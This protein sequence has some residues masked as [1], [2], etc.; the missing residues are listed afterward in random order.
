MQLLKWM[1]VLTQE[2]DWRGNKMA[3]TKVGSRNDPG[4]EALVHIR[5]LSPNTAPPGNWASWDYY[6]MASLPTND[7]PRYS[8]YNTNDDQDILTTRYYR[9]QIG[10]S[11][12]RIQ[13]GIYPAVY[14]TNLR[15][16]VKLPPVVFPEDP[17]SSGYP[18]YRLVS[19]TL[20]SNEFGP[21]Y[22]YEE[23]PVALKDYDPENDYY[24][25]YY[26][27]VIQEEDQVHIKVQDF[28]QYDDLISIKSLDFAA[29]ANFWL[30]N[31]G[32][33]IPHA[34]KMSAVLLNIPYAP[35]MTAQVKLMP[36]GVDND[37][38]EDRHIT[39]YQDFVADTGKVVWDFI[40]Y[41]VYQTG[42]LGGT[43]YINW[44]GVPDI[45]FAFN[46]L[47][48]GQDVDQK[49]FEN[50]LPPMN[51]Y[52]PPLGG[53]EVPSL[54]PQSGVIILSD[55]R[56]KVQRTPYKMVYPHTYKYITFD[57]LVTNEFENSFIQ[58]DDPANMTD[59]PIP[60]HLARKIGNEIHTHV[61]FGS[62]VVQDLNGAKMPFGG[63]WEKRRSVGVQNRGL[64]LHELNSFRDQSIV[65]RLH[66]QG[67]GCKAAH[68]VYRVGTVGK[69]SEENFNPAASF[70]S[71]SNKDE[72]I[73]SNNPAVLLFNNSSSFYSRLP[74][75]WPWSCRRWTVES[76]IK[77][78]KHSDG[79][80]TPYQQTKYYTQ[81]QEG[82][83]QEI[84]YGDIP[85]V[86]IQFN[87]WT[88]DESTE[89]VPILN[90]DPFPV[91]EIP[92][93]KKLSPT[94][95]PTDDKTKFFR[96]HY[97]KKI[98]IS[99]AGRLG[100]PELR[101]FGCDPEKTDKVSLAVEIFPILH[102]AQC[103]LIMKIGY[104]CYPSGCSY[105]DMGVGNK[106][107]IYPF[108]ACK[109][110]ESMRLDLGKVNYKQEIPV[111]IEADSLEFD[112]AEGYIISYLKLDPEPRPA[113]DTKIIY[114]QVDI[115]GSGG[116]VKFSKANDV[117]LSYLITPNKNG[118]G[119][120][121]AYGYQDSITKTLNEDL[122]VQIP[123]GYYMTTVARKECYL[124][125]NKI[126]YQSVY[127][128]FA[129]D[130]N[131]RIIGDIEYSNTF[132]C[133]EDPLYNIKKYDPYEHPDGVTLSLN[134]QKSINLYGFTGYISVVAR[135][136]CFYTS[137]MYIYQRKDNNTFE[138]TS[139]PLN[140]IYECLDKDG[141]TI[142]Y[143]GRVSI[144][145]NGTDFSEAKNKVVTGGDYYLDAK[146]NQ[147]L[148]NPCDQP[149][150]SEFYKTTSIGNAGGFLDWQ[151]NCC[152][153]CPEKTDGALVSPAKGPSYNC[154]ILDIEGTPE[155]MNHYATIGG[156]D[157]QM[158]SK[159]VNTLIKGK[160]KL[161]SK[162]K[163]FGEQ[164]PPPSF[165]DSS[166]Y[167]YAQGV[168]G[169]LG[170]GFLPVSGT[171][172]FNPSVFTYSSV[173]LMNIDANFFEEGT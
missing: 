105:P 47:K 50:E 53:P 160:A 96:G 80:I 35:R 159:C 97:Y 48:A 19:T 51:Y 173:V 85:N 45:S 127:D 150:T 169:I 52:S 141:N 67:V 98:P 162:A 3:Y 78:N 11:D 129:K 103:K 77:Y 6:V 54:S 156:C 92:N 20:D 130:Y 25:Y 139:S 55:K 16:K 38:G 134:E 84:S 30:T 41:R 95:T 163:M 58:K 4:N 153:F 109:F 28:G 83:K 88:G 154:A 40:P 9:Y 90:S 31:D 161:R 71:L 91:L 24:N 8:T 57:S 152:D 115:I 36:T 7:N 81:N 42:E 59:Q 155:S 117:L 89:V 171:A 29:Y 165:L 49:A 167:M 14:D 43:G 146:G 149:R 143:L 148:F 23:I 124:T 121:D 70:G 102:D 72:L 170:S 111:T 68:L 147:I 10:P 76:T 66:L 15:Y 166:G 73:T 101:T 125:S 122:T 131:V 22:K 69:A 120:I 157:S 151:G 112:E 46:N 65:A 104:L 93:D 79:T 18:V 145:G 33:T 116:Y 108:N 172:E 75:C 168:L 128:K 132:D 144:L 5:R 99:S 137:D 56:G 13:R 39:F 100:D 119:L 158:N 110:N 135:K 82:K 61:P 87:S 133:P 2:L 136:K 27:M 113:P 1:N 63:G 86:T 138:V 32:P 140:Q 34:D 126:I 123:D 17:Q 94:L 107:I 21:A 164:D 44:T 26:P 142:D 60:M 37:N 12:I 62:G 74:E 114:P 64:P 106:K 118:I